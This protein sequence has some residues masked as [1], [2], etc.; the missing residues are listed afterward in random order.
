MELRTNEPGGLHDYT[1][2]QMMGTPESGLPELSDEVAVN[3]I[4]NA[5][6]MPE[7]FTYI[8]PSGLMKEVYENNRNMA[9]L[10]KALGSDEVQNADLVDAIANADKLQAAQKS[11]FPNTYDYHTGNYKPLDVT[12]KAYMAGRVLGP[13][14]GSAEASTGIPLQTLLSGAYNKYVLKQPSGIT[15]EKENA[16]TTQDWYRNLAKT[17]QGKALLEQLKKEL[18]KRDAPEGEQ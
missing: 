4:V 14:L 18:E 9:R 2:G 12:S 10:L 3:S 6:K 5:L 1:I 16:Y 11:W 7:T 8:R 13:G 17:R 15:K